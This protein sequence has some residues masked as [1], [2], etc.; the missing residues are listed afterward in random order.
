MEMEEKE[1]GWMEGWRDGGMV[2]E[3]VTKVLRG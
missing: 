3:V 1:M 2:R